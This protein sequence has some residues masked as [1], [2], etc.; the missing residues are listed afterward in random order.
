LPCLLASR[1]TESDYQAV[2][3]AGKT[4]PYDPENAMKWVQTIPQGPDRTKALQTIYQNMPK[5]S[6]AA[7][8]FA[9]ENGLTE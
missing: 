2:A 3:S 4:Y 6:D 5:D 9:R 8:A 7:K 1:I